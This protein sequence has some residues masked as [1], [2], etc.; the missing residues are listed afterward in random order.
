MDAASYRLPFANDGSF[1]EQFR[2]MQEAAS[3]EKDQQSSQTGSPN[4]NVPKWQTKEENSGKATLMGREGGIKIKMKS[5][6]VRGS[7]LGTRPLPVASTSSLT[8]IFD[9]PESP[10][11][12]EKTGTRRG[13]RV[14]P[15]GILLGPHAL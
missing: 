7:E 12:R 2:K 6:F 5:S 3:I 9:R 11:Q 15:L 14:W 4:M 1:M 8:G 10:E 13:N